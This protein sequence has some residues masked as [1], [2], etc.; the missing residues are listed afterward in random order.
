MG[1]ISQRRIKLV[2]AS[3]EKIIVITLDTITPVI[4]D[5]SQTAT[6][7]ITKISSQ[8]LIVTPAETAPLI[9]SPPALVTTH[10]AKITRRTSKHSVLCEERKQTEGL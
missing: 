4:A 9:L 8:T 2:D 1:K 3:Q 10:K 6:R 5:P 7:V